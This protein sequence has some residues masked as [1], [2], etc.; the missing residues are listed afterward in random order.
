MFSVAGG[1]LVWWIWE[2]V[3]LAAAAFLCCCSPLSSPAGVHVGAI[4]C[5]CFKGLAAFLA[6]AGAFVHQL[7]LS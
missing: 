6:E 5:W 2:L 1:L 7:L 4:L 3:D